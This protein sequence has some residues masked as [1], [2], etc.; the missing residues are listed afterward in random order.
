MMGLRRDFFILILLLLY[1]PLLMLN[2]GCERCGIVG[3][4]MITYL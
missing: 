3:Q 1:Y 2:D 4:E